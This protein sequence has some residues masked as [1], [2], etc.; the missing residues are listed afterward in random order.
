MAAS[1]GA[2]GRAAIDEAF[3]GY[4]KG[5]PDVRDISAAELNA[6]QQDPSTQLVLLDIRTP[7]EQQVHVSC[8]TCML[9]CADS[10]YLRTSE[11]QKVHVHCFTCMMLCAGRL[12]LLGSMQ[13][14]VE[15]R[16]VGAGKQQT[17]TEELIC[18]YRRSR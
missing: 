6:L 18:A 9:L 17:A 3:K 8:F 15:R 14:V 11:E 2:A 13:H 1:D 4:K 5:F 10:L 12:Y 16:H 7:E